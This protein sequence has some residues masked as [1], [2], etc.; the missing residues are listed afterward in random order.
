MLPPPPP[1]VA[2]PASKVVPVLSPAWFLLPPPT[3][4]K[5]SVTRLTANPLSPPPPMLAPTT[6][7]VTLLP[8]KPPIRLGLVAFAC[9]TKPWFMEP[10]RLRLTVLTELAPTKSGA[11]CV[12]LK[13]LA[14]STRANWMESSP[15]SVSASVAVEMLVRPEPSPVKSPLVV[16]LPLP[17][18]L[19]TCV[20]VTPTT[21]RN[22]PEARIRNS[23]WVLEATSALV[24]SPQTKA[25]S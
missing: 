22:P 3:V 6:P 5:S 4:P 9:T 17:S 8:L 19:K 18:T 10:L 12:P 23:S 1:T 14:A 20:G 16:T 25:P 7:A 11:V 13:V 21:I 24:E 2:N 15:S